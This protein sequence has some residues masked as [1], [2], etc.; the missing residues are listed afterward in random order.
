MRLKEV[1]TFWI[2]HIIFKTIMFYSEELVQSFIDN[3]KNLVDH[4]NELQNKEGNEKYW[5]EHSFKGLL[6]SI[7]QESIKEE[8]GLVSS[9]YP[10]NVKE[11]L[12]SLKRL[13]TWKESYSVEVEEEIIHSYSFQHE[14][15]SKEDMIAHIIDYKEIP[16]EA[17]DNNWEDIQSGIE[18]GE[19]T[20]QTVSVKV[21]DIRLQKNPLPPLPQ[22]QIESMRDS[23]K[24][25]GDLSDS[26]ADQLVEVVLNH[27]YAS[28]AK[29]E[30][31]QAEAEAAV[32]V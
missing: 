27:I 25:V 2:F 22:E 30:R 31:N 32:A 26:Q 8:I 23:L 21:S 5:A 11:L 15:E 4:F 20:S 24:R 16:E 13:F 7:I 10:S 19:E 18:R 17:G 14:C 9:F 29:W 6:E 1:E 3:D 28:E 12:P